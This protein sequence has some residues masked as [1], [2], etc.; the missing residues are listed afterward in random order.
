MLAPP[1][2]VDARGVE[3]RRTT[4]R[5][6]PERGELE[7]TENG[8]TIALRSQSLS[9]GELLRIADHLERV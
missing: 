5:Y 7:W 2:D 6:S 9:L 1:V 4:G 3:V 8:I